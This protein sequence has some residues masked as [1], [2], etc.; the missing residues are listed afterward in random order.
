MNQPLAPV[1][2]A[3]EQYERYWVPVVHGPFA[4]DLVRRAAPRPGERVLDIACGT[5]IV[6]RTIGH[7]VP[8]VGGLTGL[9]INLLMLEVAR[10]T[11]VAEG[12][13]I[14]WHEGSAESLPF[15]D[16]A[17]DL[18][19]LQQ[20][21]QLVP[22]QQA[23]V[24][25]MLRVL[26]AGGRVAIS[27]WT[28][29]ERNPVDHIVAQAFERHLGTPIF[30]IAF[31]LGDPEVFAALFTDAGFV[32]V[33]ME[34]VALPARYAEALEYVDLLVVAAVASIPA[35]SELPHDEQERIAA[36]M[37]A[38]IGANLSPY[39]DEGALVVTSETRVLQARKPG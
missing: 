3:A 19:V 10:Q 34:V 33:A 26:S 25:E 32:D 24:S 6:A 4:A 9:D 29:I 1:E 27:A 22:D 28:A 30:D 17:F 13:D 31:S 15:E 38:D 23:A 39:I 16:A 5:G 2:N 14:E 37:K 36:A 18:L 20:A 8:E 21:L 11:A 12:L 35:L 7:S